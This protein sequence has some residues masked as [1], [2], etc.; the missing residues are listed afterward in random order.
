MIKRTGPPC[1]GGIGAPSC[2]PREQRIFVQEVFDRNVGGPAVVVGER[3]HK[4]RFGFDARDVRAI[5][6]VGTPPQ[7]L[8]S[9]DQR[10]T[11]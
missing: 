4:L 2:R 9:R 1:S 10:V 8:S 6:R 5:S 7:T 11:Q 3:Q